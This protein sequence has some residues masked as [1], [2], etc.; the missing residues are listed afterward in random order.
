M[1]VRLLRKLLAV[2]LFGTAGFVSPSR[3]NPGS[4]PR[5]AAVENAL[6]DVIRGASTPRAAVRFALDR[7]NGLN[8]HFGWMPVQRCSE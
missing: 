2:F 8:A 5:A 3:P 1:I 7:R 6:S 4:S